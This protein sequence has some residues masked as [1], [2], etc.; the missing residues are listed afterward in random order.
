MDY[1][2]KFIQDIVSKPIY[3][4]EKIEYTIRSTLKSKSVKSFNFNIW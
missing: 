4:P 1:I 3:E 2:D